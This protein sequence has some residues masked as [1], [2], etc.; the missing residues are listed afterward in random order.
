MSTKL[1][2]AG[3]WFSEEQSEREMRVKFHLRSLGFEVFSPREESL[4]TS[5]SVDRES[6][7]KT[8]ENNINSILDCDAVFAITNGKDMG[9][10]LEAGFAY[11]KG[12]PV[13]YFAEGLTGDFN[14]ML[15]C[16]GKDVYTNLDD[17]TYDRVYGV[18]KL[19][20][21]HEYEGNVE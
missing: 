13:I 11:G 8:F 1:Y 14:L 3:P 2:L 5:P 10:I 17:V 12:V 20:E 4:I 21:V 16:S 18:A 19:G 6:R 7:L 9:T 15:A